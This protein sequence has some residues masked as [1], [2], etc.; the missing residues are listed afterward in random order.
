MLIMIANNFLYI[1]ELF[2]FFISFFNIIFF[3]IIDLNNNY[4][5]Y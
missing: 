5:K 4:R 1:S 2:W 3:A